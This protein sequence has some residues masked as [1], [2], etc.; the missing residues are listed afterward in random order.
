MVE[1]RSTAKTDLAPFT[2]RSVGNGFFHV[3]DLKEKHGTI[4]IDYLSN[5]D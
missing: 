3:G 1:F 4:V 5:R 2:P